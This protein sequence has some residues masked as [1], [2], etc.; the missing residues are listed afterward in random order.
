VVVE[1]LQLSELY[2]SAQALIYPSLYEGFGMPPLEALAVGTPV[3]TTNSSS[4]PEATSNLS[5][6]IS[7]HS[8][9]EFEHA[10]VKAQELEWKKHIKNEGPKWA[11]KF[12]WDK[13]AKAIDSAIC[14]ALK[15]PISIGELNRFEIL[16]GYTIDSAEIQ[17]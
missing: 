11:C 5:I 6:T 7:G 15:T 10:L 14:K 4:L 2:A 16:Q 3:I 9:L 1:D 8:I 12:T 13:T 17:R